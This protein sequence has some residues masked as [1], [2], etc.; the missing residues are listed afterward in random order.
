MDD[1]R[2]LILSADP[3]A[4]AGLAALLTGQPG[5]T[6]V[7]QKAG[8]TDLLDGITVYRPDVVVWDLGWD[9]APALEHLT[10]LRDDRFPI[11]VLLTDENLATDAWVA[12]ARGLLLR[13][14]SAE[15][16]VAALQAITRGLAVLDPTLAKAVLPARERPPG[17]L[18][19][20]LTPRELEVLQF[21][22]EGL[23]NKTIAHQLGIS[24]HTIKFHVNSILG[25]LGAQSRTE[26]VVRAT[27]LGLII[28]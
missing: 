1:L 6:V 14:A 4:R 24:E 28:L 10:G 27:R 21:L 8:E 26:A 17:P 3:L 5:C 7:G 20:D 9:P 12:G 13:D 18:V 22:A 15:E 2:I 11:V 25:K 23:P 16:L 19:E